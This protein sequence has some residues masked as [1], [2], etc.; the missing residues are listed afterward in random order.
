MA[1]S[2]AIGLAIGENIFLSYRFLVYCHQENPKMSGIGA[3][4]T[5]SLKLNPKCRGILCESPLHLGR[6]LKACVSPD[7]VKP[8][9]VTGGENASVYGGREIEGIEGSFISG[10]SAKLTQ[11]MAT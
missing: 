1:R 11:F 10:F 7:W 8:G 2:Q 6:I 3:G 5:Q 4:F 9:P